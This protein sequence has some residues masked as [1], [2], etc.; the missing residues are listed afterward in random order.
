MLKQKKTFTYF[1]NPAWWENLKWY[2]AD[3]KATLSILTFLDTHPG[4]ICSLSK[5]KKQLKKYHSLN[6]WPWNECDV[7]K[8]AIKNVTVYFCCD[9][10]R[11]F[12][13]RVDVFAPHQH[14]VLP[15]RAGRCAGPFRGRRRTECQGLPSRHTTETS[16]P[17]TQH[18]EVKIWDIEWLEGRGTA[19]SIFFF[20][21]AGIY[22]L[23]LHVWILL[24]DCTCGILMYFNKRTPTDHSSDV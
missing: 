13:V 8:Q 22:I 9:S 6:P 18:T 16:S 17:G 10:S 21:G 14:A 24:L 11:L 4:N 23:I 5:K 19:G 20:S 1:G 7:W 3:N 12:E 2:F 15:D